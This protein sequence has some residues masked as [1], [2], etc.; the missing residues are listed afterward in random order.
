MPRKS[1]IKN[2]WSALLKKTNS[3]F[4]NPYKKVGINWFK[5]K[6]YKHLPAGPLRSHRLYGKYIYF[7]SAEE[8]LHGF[9]EIFLENIY[10]QELSDNPYILD[11][12]ANIGLSVIYLKTL[13]PDASIVAF[14]PDEKNFELLKKNT[15]S[16][17]FT[18]IELRKE[19]VWIE[20]TTLQFASE[21]SM[22]SKIE[23]TASENVKPVK[24]IRLKDL[25]NRNIDFL[26]MDIE[27][28]EYDVVND[29]KEKL[30]NVNNLFIEYHGSFA[31]NKELTALF[32]IISTNGFSY[33][34]K[35]A[36]TVYHTPFYR[37]KEMEKPFDVQLNI[38]CFRTK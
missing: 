14:E 30:I 2:T 29:I 7:Y 10:K 23:M 1:F 18:G 13:F 32:E 20:N 31:Q 5:L 25:M 9:K 28:A 24:A 19:A 3:V 34:I 4:A 22:S 8:L 12:G 26:K 6:Y 17:A 33:Y 35:E 27:G 37:S 36:T 21:G 16:F 11:C 38:F 15:D